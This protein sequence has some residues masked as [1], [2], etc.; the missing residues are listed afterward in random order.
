MTDLP[1]TAIPSDG[2]VIVAKR[3]CPTCTLIEPVMRAIDRAG[4]L[5]VFTQ[6]DPT[7]P[8]G[9]SRVVDDH[10]LERSFRLNVETVPTL[11]RFQGGKEVERTVGWDVQEWSRMAGPVARVN[12]LPSFQPGCG[13]KSVEQI[14]RAHV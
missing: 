1:A 12:G 4:P 9:V 10:A 13:S 11:I 14:G 2:F 6:D 5:T 7:F 3:D 8:E